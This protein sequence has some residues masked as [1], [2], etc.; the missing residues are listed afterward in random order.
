MGIVVCLVQF[1]RSVVS[2]SLRPHEL[3]HASLPFTI[4][5]SLLKLTSITSVMPSNHLILCRPLLPLL[6]IFPSIRVFS[7]E[8][9]LPTRW[10]EY[11]SFSWAY[12]PLKEGMPLWGLST[13]HPLLPETLCPAIKDQC[14]HGGQCRIL[15]PSGLR[16][17]R[18]SFTGTIEL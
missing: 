18:L 7:N 14:G 16:R 1:S 13:T 2:D 4:S 5:W 11:W 8:L 12:G 15:M 17:Q 6:S 3:Q 9:A 10:P